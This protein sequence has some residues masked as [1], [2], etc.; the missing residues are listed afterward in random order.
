MKQSGLMLKD[1]SKSLSLVALD[2]AYNLS[3]WFGKNGISNKE[4]NN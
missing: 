1:F 4:Y 2:Q 3:I